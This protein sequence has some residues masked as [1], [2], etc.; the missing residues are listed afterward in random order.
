[1]GG[2]GGRVQQKRSNELNK[3][4]TA[5]QASRA[6]TSTIRR[7]IARNLLSS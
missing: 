3:I 7:H 6:T 5:W 4:S 1:M 2:I